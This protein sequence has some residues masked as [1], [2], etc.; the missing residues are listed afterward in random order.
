[1]QEYF[2]QGLGGNGL[3]SWYKMTHGGDDIVQYP[4]EPEVLDCHDPKP[5]IQRLMLYTQPFDAPYVVRKFAGLDPRY[6]VVLNTVIL[7]L[8]LGTRE[9]PHRGMICLVDSVK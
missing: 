3:R 4:W 2:E 8:V 9:L 7:P 6:V 5:E 1:M